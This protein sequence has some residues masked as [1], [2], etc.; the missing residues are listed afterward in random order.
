MSGERAL[1][2][3]ESFNEA[4]LSPSGASA[5]VFVRLDGPVLPGLSVPVRAASA[6]P[7]VARDRHLFS[8]LRQRQRHERKDVGAAAA[9]PPPPSPA[10]A[11]A[12]W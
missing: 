1:N 8:E 12:R 2:H 3:G 7:V 10:A 5:K 6:F 9:P 4:V 11:A